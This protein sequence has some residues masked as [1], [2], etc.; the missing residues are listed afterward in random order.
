MTSQYK[1]ILFLS[2]WDI[3]AETELYVEQDLFKLFL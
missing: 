1:R 3:Y 2:L